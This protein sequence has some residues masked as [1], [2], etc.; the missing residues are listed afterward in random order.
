MD[1]ALYHVEARKKLMGSQNVER[2]EDHLSTRTVN[3]VE[4]GSGMGR[5]ALYAT[6]THKQWSVNGIE[7]STGLHK[8]AVEI[9]EKAVQANLLTK[10][11]S[12][13]STSMPSCSSS[14]L[15]L[16]SAIP[17]TES[18]E[19]YWDSRCKDDDATRSIQSVLSSADLIFSYSTAFPAKNFDPIIGALVLDPVWSYTLSESCPSGCVAVTTD[20]ALDPVYGWEL[21]ERINVDN[22]EVFGTTGFISILRK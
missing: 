3:F 6:L 15:H 9:T 21:L 16:G 20:R 18:Y 7:I 17:S 2:K 14:S 5:I 19:S 4:I 22:P 1:A 12:I 8:K 10:L 13:D 11:S